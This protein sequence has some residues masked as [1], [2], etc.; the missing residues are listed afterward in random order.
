M[1]N[2]AMCWMG[3]FCWKQGNQPIKPPQ[4]YILCSSA[5]GKGLWLLPCALILG[6]RV[7]VSRAPVSGVYHH[8]VAIGRTTPR[9]SAQL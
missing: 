5:P 3:G 2:L 8:L 6:G 7:P 1:I 9:P 4:D